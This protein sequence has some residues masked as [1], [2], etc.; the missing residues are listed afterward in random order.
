MYIALHRSVLER[1]ILKVTFSGGA[2]EL[3]DGGV[4]AQGSEFAA[5]VLIAVCEPAP[6][7]LCGRPLHLQAGR[8][9]R[10]LRPIRHIEGMISTAEPVAR[11]GG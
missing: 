5:L 4:D 10:F 1:D 3:A 7:R 6:V 11:P 2:V 9:L 8:G